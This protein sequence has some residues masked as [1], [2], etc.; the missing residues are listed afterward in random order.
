MTEYYHEL[1]F[2]MAL[3]HLMG[4]A[5]RSDGKTMRLRPNSFVRILASAPEHVQYLR[6][7]RTGKWA[8]HF[9]VGATDLRIELTSEVV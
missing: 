6:D 8:P 7:Y 2:E 5:H 1:D 3:Q 9:N 4:A